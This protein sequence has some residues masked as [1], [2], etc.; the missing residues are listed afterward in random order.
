MKQ[1]ARLRPAPERRHSSQPAVQPAELT[2]SDS[3][4]TLT[5]ANADTLRRYGAGVA[6]RVCCDFVR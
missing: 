3:A 4:S 6:A 1:R 5:R 2:A